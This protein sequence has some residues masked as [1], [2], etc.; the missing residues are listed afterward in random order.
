MS[1]PKDTSGRSDREYP[2]SSG[3]RNTENPLAPDHIKRF[4]GGDQRDPAPAPAGTTT[5]VDAGKTE[6]EK[7]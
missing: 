1:T 7:R 5:E 4:K 3:D 2:H 6:D